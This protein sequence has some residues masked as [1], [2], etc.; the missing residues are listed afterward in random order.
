MITPRHDGGRKRAIG[1]KM[2]VI[3]RQLRQRFDTRV[4]QMGV[5]RAKWMLIA[6]VAGDPGATQR[7]IATRLEVSD[8]TA[9]RLI[10][11]VCADGLVERRENPQ[12]RRAYC[13]YLTEA[14]EPLLKK[15]T[16]TAEAYEAEVFADFDDED[17]KL[18]DGLLDR[19]S[20]N[21]NNRR[22]APDDGKGAEPGEDAA[23]ERM[24]AH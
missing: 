24:A 14:A 3:A 7:M 9:G 22:D 6:S 13:V 2:A 21:L 16:K 15:L 17:L 4:E 19:M 23:S 12:D 18:L 8:V 11:K 5:T 10:D 1:V 20:R